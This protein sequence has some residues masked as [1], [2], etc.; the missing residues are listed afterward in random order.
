MATG[1][2]LV[3]HERLLD[4]RDVGPDADRAICTAARQALALREI[5]SSAL[6]AVVAAYSCRA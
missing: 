5:I 6:V 1:R 4:R 3:I 2:H